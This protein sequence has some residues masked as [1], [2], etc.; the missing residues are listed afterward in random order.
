M[1]E[2]L[3]KLL[4]Y[5]E[6]Y[7]QLDDVRVEEIITLFFSLIYMLNN[8]RMTTISLIS[9]IIEKKQYQNILKELIG[10]D[11]FKY[12]LKRFFLKENTLVNSKIIKKKLVNFKRKNEKLNKIFNHDGKRKIRL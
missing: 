6:I 5:K 3:E 1:K 4:S 8:K 11:N 7:N 10:A 9:S 2:E 12:I